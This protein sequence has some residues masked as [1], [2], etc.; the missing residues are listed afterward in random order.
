MQ[1]KEEILKLREEIKK[2]NKLYYDN[3]APIISDYEYDAMLRRLEE[4]ENAHPELYS[5]DS[6]T[7]KVGGSVKN[8]F[9]KVSHEVPLE[10][11]VDVFSK[12]ELSSSLIK[13]KKALNDDCLFCV[14]PKVDGLS[15]SLKYI[16]GVFI[17]AATRGDG[18][19]GEDVTENVR[20]IKNVP[21]KLKN[22][23][24]EL[25][26][27][28]EVYMSKAVFLSLNEERQIAQEPLFANPRNAAAGSMRQLNP[29]IAK[30]RS[31]DFIAFNI[32]KADVATFASHFE[33]VKF[34]SDL[35]F[36]TVPCDR[37]KEVSEC[38]LRIDEI[39]DDR[40]KFPFEIDGAVVK[41]DKLS[42]REYL[43]S[44]SKAP[45]WAVAYKY[46]PEVKESTVLDITVQVGRTG[47]VTPKAVLSPVRLSGTTVTNATL[48]NKDI[49]EKLDIRIGDTVKVRKAG[50][51]IPEI[52]E[53]VL[54]K[55]PEG[56]LPFKMP[57]HCPECGS[58]LE[59]DFEGVAIRC[60]GLECPAQVLRNIVH[61]AS[62]DAMDIEGLGIG[63]ARILISN[64]LIS[65]PADIYY[66]DAEKIATLD[67]MGKKSAQN[68]I[69]AISKSKSAGLARLITAFGIRQV[70][71][72]M[73]QVLAFEFGTLDN[74]NNAT[75]DELTG[76][77][78]VGSITAGFIKKWFSNPQSVHQIARLREAGVSF[79]ADKP[80]IKGDKFSGLTFVL[81]GTLS[82]Y[83][84]DDATNIIVSLGG[85]VS[86]SVSKNTSYVLV[87]DS[88]GSKLKK[89]EA[90][91]VK[92][93]SE[94]EFEKLISSENF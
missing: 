14:E 70:G 83:S 41:V 38:S 81:T 55:R 12:E 39:S 58:L 18:Q 66:L 86:S 1:Y 9:E 32:Q 28:G 43:G 29:E 23:P 46:P 62:K 68:L 92:V 50:E 16:N 93:L 72:K 56:T 75:A 67:G 57:E 21:K 7:Q 11:L 84:R 53:V 54:S 52:V 25:V 88:P 19:T 22:A 4:L 8:S 74:L 24:N 6:P 77:P 61:F 63:V 76:V 49:V 10:S 59:E 15:M 71:Q 26:I 40:E 36:E 45:R 64:G 34:L 91:N 87:G 44:T 17:Q 2:H 20:T 42:Q 94:T 79:N 80:A 85:K 13:M 82:S 31:L 73:S 27:R 35:G 30:S 48:H 60:P 78:E 33:S 3:D 65:S 69:S 89:A 90:L 5:P 37:Y 51:I 47:A